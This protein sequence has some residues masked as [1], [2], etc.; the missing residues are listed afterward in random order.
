M[1]NRHAYLIMAHN[2]PELLEQLLHALDYTGNDIY[3][4]LDAKMDISGLR[5]PPMRSGTLFVLEDRMDVKW[6]DFTQIAC[7]LLLLERAAGEKHAYYHLLSGVD[8]PLKPQ[9]EIHRFFAENSG[10]EFIQFYG[11]EID[12]ETRNRVAK[13]HFLVKRRTEKSVFH[14][15]ACKALLGIQIAVDR[16]RGT[17]VV[18]QKGA[19]WFS[20]S[21]DLAQYVLSRKTFILKHF[22]YTLCGD[23]M[24]LQTLVYNSKFRERVVCGNFCDN[25]QN[26]LYEIDWKRGNPYEYTLNE[27]N[28]L[29]DS[30]MLFAR[31]FNWYKDSEVIRKIVDTVAA[32]EW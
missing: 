11:P 16:T 2:Q 17:G 4:H 14:K 31:K 20:I 23:E 25:Y 15:L 13:Y 21:E 5:I 12:K 6:G 27:Y 28:D 1:S 32:E 10:T 9:R 8:L 19:N 7:E 22:R 3:L 26:I 18:F 24:F 29:M 30:G